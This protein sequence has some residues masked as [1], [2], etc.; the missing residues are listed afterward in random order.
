MRAE[1]NGN[2]VSGLAMPNRIVSS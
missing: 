1:A 2:F